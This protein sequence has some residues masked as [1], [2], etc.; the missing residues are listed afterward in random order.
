MKKFMLFYVDAGCTDPQSLIF[1]EKNLKSAFA[2]AKRF[3][4]EHNKM[5]LGVVDYCFITKYT[6]L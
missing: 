3:C 1:S 2:F 6:L 5:F 4:K